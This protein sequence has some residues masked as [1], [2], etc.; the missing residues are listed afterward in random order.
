MS[1]NAPYIILAGGETHP[2]GNIYCIGRN[3]AAHA[4]ELNNPKPDKPIVF[5][6]PTTAILH[7]GDTLVLPAGIGEIHHEV[8]LVVLLNGGGRNIPAEQA[9]QYVEAYAV[10]IDVT[11]RDLQQKLK[12]AGH[13][14]LIAKGYDGFA[15]VS[16]F[17]PADQTGDAD[18]LTITLDINGKRVQSGRV[19]D[20]LF[21]L[22]ELIGYLSSIFSLRAGDLIFTGTPEGVGPLHRADQLLAT[23]SNAGSNS[24]CELRLNCSDA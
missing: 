10:G 8:E 17:I 11:A 5:S 24:I 23:L 7:D 6:K 18:A 4:A 20:M 9:M 12:A 21:S 1:D 2:V 22:P 13:P 16:E 19:K 3:Y 14:W 15:P